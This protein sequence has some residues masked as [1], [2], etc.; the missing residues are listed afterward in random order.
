TTELQKD[1]DGASSALRASLN[2][3]MAE[4][5]GDP[6]VPG[7]ASKRS[8]FAFL[9]NSEMVDFFNAEIVDQF[10]SV[11]DDWLPG[12][13]VSVERAAYLSLAY[14]GIIQ[15]DGFSPNLNAAVEDGDR[16]EAWF[17]I[18]YNT[19]GGASRSTGI[20]KRRYVESHLHSLY[21]DVEA[22]GSVS[23]L[24]ALQVF[25]MFTKHENRILQ[26]EDLF[27]DPAGDAIGDLGAIESRSGLELG[28]VEARE[29]SFQPAEDKLVANFAAL[30]GLIAAQLASIAADTALI[31]LNFDGIFVA[32]S[33]AASGEVAA[34]TVDRAGDLQTHL[35]FGAIEQDGGGAD[36]LLG[37]TGADHF[38]GG[39]GADTMNGDA[40]EDTVDYRRSG[41]GVD[42]NLAAETGAGGDAA[43]DRLIAVENLIGSNFADQ[44]RG[45]ASGNILI[46][47][48]GA[49]ALFAE[50]GDDTLF[51]GA[52]DDEI[53]AAAGADRLYGGEGADELY[54]GDGDAGADSLF[55]EA[56]GD[57]LIGGGGADLLDGGSGPDKL[58]GDA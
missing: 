25:R 26:E 14:N 51:G 45:T 29:A 3:I 41:A 52:G 31:D 55:G 56:G 22:D 9:S 28:A 12:V 24:Q 44:L 43:G 34:N 53:F 10:E 57:L 4:R 46:G 7:G 19:N 16:A 5:A 54:G 11:V 8:E 2:S 42:V 17:E 50:A 30:P 40:G 6:S 13:P 1:W 39:S 18:R 36:S 15:G 48:G 27:G 32:P 49:D 23:E 37:G 33:S 21:D 20:A 38:I 35:I 58:S 47:E